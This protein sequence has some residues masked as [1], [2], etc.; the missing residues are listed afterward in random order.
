MKKWIPVLGVVA[1]AMGSGAYLTS[2]SSLPAAVADAGREGYKIGAT[3]KGFSLPDAAGKTHEVGDWGASKATV[4]LYVATRCPIS[5]D[6]NA[7]MA[8]LAN[9]YTAKGIKF[10]GIN[11]NK[12]ELAPEI[13]EH[14]KE[15]KWSFPVLKD[16]GNKIADRFD[17]HVTPEVFV[18]DPKGSLVYWGNIDDS[19]KEDQVKQRG[20]KDALDAVLAGK[21]VAV[22]Q[23]RAFGCTIKR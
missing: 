4:L 2:T 9:T 3:V 12:Q 10:Y 17:A 14:A 8:S 5:N 11:S 7:R 21:E 13:A 22:K 20:L 19:R 1:V 15:N 6:Y 16:A 23:T 18:V